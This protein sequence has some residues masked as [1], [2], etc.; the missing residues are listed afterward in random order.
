M[1][2]GLYVTIKV[3]LPKDWDKLMASLGYQ[4]LNN[5]QIEQRQIS[6]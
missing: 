1:P 5:F 3:E 4:P 6:K 2:G